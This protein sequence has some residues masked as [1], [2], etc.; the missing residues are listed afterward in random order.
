[1]ELRAPGV[2]S[3]FAPVARTSQNPLASEQWDA[4]IYGGARIWWNWQ[5]RYFEVVVP[6]GV[7]VQV[8]LSAPLFP[9]EM[10]IR[11]L[12]TQPGHKNRLN[13]TATALRRTLCRREGRTETERFATR[14]LH[15]SLRFARRR[16]P[17]RRASR[18][19]ARHDSRTPDIEAF[20]NVRF[21][22]QA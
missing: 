19:L 10:G 1:L 14:L 9:R 2:V 6:Q 21:F 22:S 20:E 16:K 17:D 4:S 12:L 8:L 5:T 15:V 3:R 18:Q 11:V 7:Q 13:S